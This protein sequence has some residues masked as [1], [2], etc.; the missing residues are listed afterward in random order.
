MFEHHLDFCE[1]SVTAPLLVMGPVLF[2]TSEFLC[3]C[4]Y[5]CKGDP[6]FW[7]AC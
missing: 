3:A 7:K 2:T 5:T 6:V 4:A 1:A